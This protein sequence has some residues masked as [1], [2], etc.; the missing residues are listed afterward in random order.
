MSTPAGHRAAQGLEAQLQKYK[1]AAVNLPRLVK[2]YKSLESQHAEL[3]QQSASTATA[4]DSS[5]K[6]LSEAQ[7]SNEALEHSLS[8]V[9]AERSALAASL[10]VSKRQNAILQN[11]IAG[12]QEQQATLQSSGEQPA[13]HPDTKLLNNALREV[14]ALRAE[15]CSLVL[16]KRTEAEGVVL[17]ELAAIRGQMSQLLQRCPKEDGFRASTTSRACTP[18]HESLASP[19]LQSMT[20]LYMRPG[21][22]D[23][24]RACAP[25]LV[26]SCPQDA[27]KQ[28]IAQ[29][30]S[31]ASAVSSQAALARAASDATAHARV[32][33]THECV[34]NPSVEPPSPLQRAA[35]APTVALPAAPSSTSSQ[36]NAS[37]DVTMRCNTAQ[38]GGELGPCNHPIALPSVPHTSSLKRTVPMPAGSPAK[39]SV[40][41]GSWSPH[42]RDRDDASVP[43]P[44]TC[45]TTQKK[46]HKAS[47]D[48]IAKVCFQCKEFCDV[49]E[50]FLFSI[51]YSL[52]VCSSSLL[53]IYL[54]SC[55]PLCSRSKQQRYCCRGRRIKDS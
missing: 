14:S 2:K 12:G 11:R 22:V 15:V 3:R 28:S 26:A 40:Q 37:P 45:K 6:A 47:A 18:V 36:C 48:N 33:S 20:S 43:P 5:R 44:R 16:A 35:Q 52:F 51:L 21:T 30:N 31:E 10:E 34:L 27:G 42:K 38:V 39:R 49:R 55:D 17:S 13:A 25:P 32:T 53:A 19:P 54:C 7:S 23:V 41:D 50:A 46:K 29:P 9:K 4:L 1:E 24:H 8:N